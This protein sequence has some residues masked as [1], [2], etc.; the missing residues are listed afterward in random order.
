MA[1]IYL[2]IMRNMCNCMNNIE[3]ASEIKV[4]LGHRQFSNGGHCYCATREGHAAASECK[5][6]L[7]G[8]V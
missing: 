5:S 7:M 8:A 4:F 3:M 1:H 6:A 2:Q